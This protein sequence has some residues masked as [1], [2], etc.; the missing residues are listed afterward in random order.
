ML[1]NAKF[2]SDKLGVILDIHESS[3]NSKK[4]IRIKAKTNQGNGKSCFLNEK[5][6][7]IRED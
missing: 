5:A 3:G 2:V 4:L 1:L 7:F 6:G